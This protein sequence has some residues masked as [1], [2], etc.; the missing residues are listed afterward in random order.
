MR[1]CAEPSSQCQPDIAALF[2][3]EENDHGTQAD[4]PDE[5]GE[6]RGDGGIC[7]WGKQA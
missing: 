2:I 5:P 6:K 3:H 7:K 4:E 1:L